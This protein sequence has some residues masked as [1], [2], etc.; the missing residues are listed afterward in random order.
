MLLRSMAE[1]P[2]NSRTKP[3]SRTIAGNCKTAARTWRY[4]VSMRRAM[5]PKV[6][7]QADPVPAFR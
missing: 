6:P 3:F 2:D 7:Q 5:P 1:L 4:R